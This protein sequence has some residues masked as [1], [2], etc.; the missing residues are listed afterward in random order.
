MG[1]D[2]DLE[3]AEDYGNPVVMLCSL[4]AAA[5]GLN[6]TAAN[7]VFLLDPWWQESIGEHH[8]L[9]LHLLPP[10]YFAGPSCRVNTSWATCRSRQALER[11]CFL[12]ALLSRLSPEALMSSILSQNRR[13]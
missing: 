11:C 7:N 1:L 9:P 6:L 3:F 8:S 5:L 4:K 2:S 13:R 10:F 12:A